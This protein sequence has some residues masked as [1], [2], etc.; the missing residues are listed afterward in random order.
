MP[1]FDYNKALTCST[2]CPDVNQ[3]CN[4]EFTPYWNTLH[5]ILGQQTNGN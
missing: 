2:K 1:E 3:S 5:P 4:P